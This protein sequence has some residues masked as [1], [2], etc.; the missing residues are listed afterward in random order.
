MKRELEKN[1]NPKVIEDRIYKNWLDKKYFSAKI[2]KSKKPFTIVIP[3]PNITGQLHMGHALN[4]TIQDILIRT[5]R[6]QGFPTLWLPGTDHAAI[7][8]E[9]RIVDKMAQEGITKEDLGREKFLERAWAWKD[10]YGGIITEQFKKLGSSCDWDRERFTMDEGLSAAVLEVFIR[11]YE[12]GYI[13]KGER[14]VNWCPYCET[15]ISDAEVDHEEKQ[16]H[17]WHLKYKIDGEDEYL[18]FAT[19]RPETLLGDTAI[20]VNPND[21]R[22]QKYIGKTVTVPIVNRQI[23]IIADNYVEMDFGTGVVKI[24]PA[25]DPNDF[26]VGKRHN[27]DIINIM[28]NDGTLNENAGS[29]QGLDRYEARKKIIEEFK[30]MGLFTQ[31]REISHSVGTH[32]R[33]KKTV[34][35]LIKE[36]WFVSMSE[37]AKPALDALYN[38]EV[39]FVPERFSKIYS[40]WLENIQDWCISRQIWW[41]HRIPA[42]YCEDCGHITV[43]LEAPSACEKCNSVKIYQDEDT[44]DTWFSSALWPF[45]T[46][47]WPNKTED[48]EYFFPTNVLV[49]G[50]DI[51]F[52]WVVRMVFSSI[53]NMGEVPFKDVLINGT[54]RDSQ[55]RKMSKSLDNGIDP[56]DIIAE[57]GT[58]ALRLSLILG[59]AAGADQRVSFEKIESS[60][61]F[62]NKIWNATRFAMM[63]FEDSEITANLNDLMPQDKWILSKANTLIKE[64]TQNIEN[65]ELGVAVQKIYDFAWDEFCD[66][67]IEMIK[68]RL[69][70]KDDKTRNAA[71]FTLKETL[72]II[73]KL[74]H[75]YIPF[76]TEEIFLTIQEKEETIVLSEFPKFSEELVFS[77]EEADIELIKSAIKSIRNLRAEMNVLPSKK[78]NMT[79]VCEDEKL[80]DVFKAGISF[81]QTL[82]YANEILIQN[83]NVGINKDDVAIIVSGAVIYMPFSELVDIEKE[84]LRLEKEIENLKKEVSR[85]ENKLENEGFTAKAPQK[86]IDEEKAKGEKYKA[87]LLETEKQLEKLRK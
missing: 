33:C 51:I 59:N 83:D 22:Y 57:Y 44:L 25:H 11:L 63:N 76:V 65:Y 27:L 10:E 16:G 30:E 18:E 49:T 8:T 37:M 81:L 80:G 55:G 73:L 13:Y 74:L 58:D 17:F 46:L 66:W 61:N 5:K 71:L 24:T 31:A 60:R 53:E 56:L 34:E 77:Q 82:G 47:G 28:N 2:D 45:S 75:P 21:E 68:P 4:A 14:L 43:K 54:V 79:I 36:Q 26:E 35:P 12:K 70:N 7:A 52:F 23:P 72:T 19:T 39:R 86:L 3:P 40:H 32:E 67:Y 78:V 50:Q 69:Y 42:Y 48:L 62:I 15:A 1:Y 84:I 29:Y 6:M 64:V 41:G 85:V 9:A 20:A 38:G 87:M